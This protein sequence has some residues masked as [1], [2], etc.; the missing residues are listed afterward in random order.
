MHRDWKKDSMLREIN[1]SMW[2]ILRNC[3]TV[4]VDK[5]DRKTKPNQT[6]RKYAC[7]NRRSGHLMTL[8]WHYIGNHYS[9]KS[10][11]KRQ[12]F[13]LNIL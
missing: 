2:N 11:C 1:E 3:T 12:Y 7:I 13:L 9:N 5:G 4:S 10:V 8:I 6:G